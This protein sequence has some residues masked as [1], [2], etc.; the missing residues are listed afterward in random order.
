MFAWRGQLLPEGR[1]SSLRSVSRRLAIGL[2]AL[3]LAGCALARPTEIEA[4][5]LGT[6]KVDAPFKGTYR[7]GRSL[8]WAEFVITAALNGYS[9]ADEFPSE[10]ALPEPQVQ[11]ELARLMSQPNGALWIGHS[12][13]L[14]RIKGLTLITDPVFSASASPLEVTGPKRYAPPALEIGKLP[15]ID[16]VLITHNHFD[17]LDERSL[18]GIAARFPGARI[19]LPRGNEGIARGAGFI[20]ISGLKAGQAVMLG[21]VQFTAMPA[22]HETSRMGLDAHRTLAIGWSI[23]AR[24]GTSVYFAGDTAYGPVFRKIRGLYGAHDVAFVPIGAYE[25]REEVL[26]V[27]AS[28]EESAQIAR[29]LGARLAIGMHWGTFPLSSEPIMEPAKRFRAALGNNR[30]LRIGEMIAF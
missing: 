19:L 29:E 14:I 16:A 10:L 7:E 13:F 12:T 22:Y 24:P 3:L 26:H 8:P 23:R 4:G 15:R 11:R 5:R 27:H 21:G 17:H 30:A 18:A 2:V 20:R 1:L 28:P 6:V 9:R 25:P